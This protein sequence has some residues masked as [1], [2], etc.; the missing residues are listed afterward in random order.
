MAPGALIFR[1][2]RTQRRVWDSQ[3]LLQEFQNMGQ[4]KSKI[5]P[6]LEKK[7]IRE[8]T[9]QMN[10]KNGNPNRTPYVTFKPNFITESYFTS[11][12]M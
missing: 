10:N 9:C 7:D 6:V 8:W 12:K 11:L 1:L 4:L 3:N 5:N 2:N